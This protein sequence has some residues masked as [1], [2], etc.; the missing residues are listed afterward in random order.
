MSLKA[1]RNK[2][3]MVSKARKGFKGYPIA[4]IAHYGRT[5]KKATKVVVSVVADEAGEP[6]PM[7][8]WFS[9]DDVRMDESILNEIL[10]FLSE[11]DVKSVVM[12]DKIIGCPHEEGVDYPYGQECEQC[13]FWKGRDRWSGDRLH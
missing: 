13:P 1:T 4:T 12:P 11:N 3:R 2:K 10:E 8:K 5:D 7:R 9:D 6:D